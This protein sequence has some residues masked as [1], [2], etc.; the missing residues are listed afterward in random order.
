MRGVLSFIAVLLLPF[1]IMVIIADPLC[2]LYNSLIGEK[3]KAY[4]VMFGVI[5]TWVVSIAITRL[6]ARKLLGDVLDE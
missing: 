5:S 1:L 4:A 3:G 6:V 2:G